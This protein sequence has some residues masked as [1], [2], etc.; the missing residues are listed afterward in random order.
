MTGAISR[1]AA[2]ATLTPAADGDCA[3]LEKRD[4][5]Y[6]QRRIALYC[7]EVSEHD[8]ASGIANQKR[9]AGTMRK[10]PK[11]RNAACMM[12]IRK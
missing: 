3:V 9:S 12:A 8:S 4:E 6:Q 1:L 5:E 7:G 11:E 10:L 2:E